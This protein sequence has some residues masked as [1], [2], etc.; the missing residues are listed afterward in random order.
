MWPFSKNTKSWLVSNVD[1]NW[2][3]CEICKY[4][5]SVLFN[6]CNVLLLWDHESYSSQTWTRC[7]NVWKRANKGVIDTGS[8]GSYPAGGSGGWAAARCR[9]LTGRAAGVPPVIS[10]EG[11]RGRV[12]YHWLRLISKA[13]KKS[14]SS[15]VREISNHF[16][17]GNEISEILLY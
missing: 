3:Y 14:C 8:D 5:G 11:W 9:S 12:H 1:K 16:W 2:L 17:K 13:V 6:G 15:H 10:A 4:W 7:K